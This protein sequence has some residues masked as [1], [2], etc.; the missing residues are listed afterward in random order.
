MNNTSHPA[1]EKLLEGFLQLAG[2]DPAGAK[3][4]NGFEFES[5][6][7]T[8]RIFPD[9][10]GA[11][12]VIEVDVRSLGPDEMENASLLLMLHRLN[13]SALPQHG[14][15]ATIDETDNLLLSASL[16]LTETDGLKLQGEVAGALDR[17][18]SL[19]A[20]VNQFSSTDSNA[21]AEES[22]AETAKVSTSFNPLDRA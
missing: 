12:V 20:L 16:P 8:A 6:D 21:G 1:F 15:I 22:G 9:A 14:W 19:T 4:S 11:H 2:Q 13:E 17:A 10:D 18:E 7:H 5:G 3:G